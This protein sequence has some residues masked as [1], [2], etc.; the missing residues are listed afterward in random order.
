MESDAAIRSR[1]VS[2][3]QRARYSKRTK[4]AALEL[5]AQKW[6]TQTMLGLLKDTE[7]Q[8]MSPEGS[9]E[10]LSRLADVLH[11]QPTLNTSALP[12][13]RGNQESQRGAYSHSHSLGST[14][15]P[16]RHASPG[17]CNITLALNGMHIYFTP[18][19]FLLRP[20]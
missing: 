14:F 8:E 12:T 13:N 5:E 17:T 6:K 1:L 16:L 4:Q 10:M 11:S 2:S 19:F 20:R 18:F 3:R 15:P 9:V 7:P